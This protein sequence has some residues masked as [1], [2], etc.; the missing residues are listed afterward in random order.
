MGRMRGVAI[1]TALLVVALATL[2]VT[3]VMWRQQVQARSVE[4]QIALA[5]IRWLARGA[6]D[7]AR[8]ILMQDEN[9]TTVDHMGEAWA[10]PIA[11]LE[12][13]TITDSGLAQGFLSGEIVD[14]QGRFNVLD[15]ARD[16]KPL[17][18]DSP[19]RQRFGRLLAV[20][21]LS[22]ELVAGVAD[23]VARTQPRAGADGQVK[24]GLTLPVLVA[25]DLTRVAGIDAG[26]IE[27]LR[28]H[29]T[30][31]PRPAADPL[32]VNA[33]TA[34]AEVLY[35]TIGKI[36]VQQAQLLV[37]ERERIHF[38]QTADI[39]TRLGGTLTPADLEG[40]DVHSNF[41]RVR[42]RL[43]YG[44]ALLMTEALIFRQTRGLQGGPYTRILWRQES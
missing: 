15:L 7:W 16:G 20:L 35:A 28:P 33:N 41:F 24:A 18:E 27:R 19:P 1:I 37:R 5:E 29:V 32:K 38:Q 12:I 40:L 43:R 44:R 22:Q 4:N 25:D 11:E 36:T 31:L 21:G 23:A 10:L 3:G 17:A 13:S 2:A 6:S 26:V 8:Q 30:F 34:S 42:G 39:V 14:E 9:T